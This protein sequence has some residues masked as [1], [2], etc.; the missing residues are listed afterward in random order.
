MSHAI[1]TWLM[2]MCVSMTSWHDLFPCAWQGM[3]LSLI[4]GH[5][6]FSRVTW[7]THTWLTHTCLVR[8]LDEI[9]TW[10][11]LMCVGSPTLTYVDM[12]HSHMWHDSHTHDSFAASMRSWH[13]LFSCVWDNSLSHTWTWLILT[14][15]ITQSHIRSLPRWRRD[16][17]HSHMRHD[18]LTHDWFAASII[19]DSPRE[20]LT[21]REN[22]MKSWF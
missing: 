17:A 16:M 7:L 18:S 6:W 11:I 1:V 2:L 19:S 13:D 12:T 15:D 4:R 9:V 5:D 20:Y 3:T 14:C 22:S 8:C 10:L 21:C